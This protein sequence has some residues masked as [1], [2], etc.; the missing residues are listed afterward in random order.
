MA[1][2]LL[3]TLARFVISPINP[4]V[5]NSQSVFGST[6]RATKYDKTEAEVSG[7]QTKESAIFFK[8]FFIW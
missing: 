8:S 7:L 1:M 3:K 6:N 5:A 2:F 4:K